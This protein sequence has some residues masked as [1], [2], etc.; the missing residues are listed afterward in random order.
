LEDAGGFYKI[1]NGG[2]A[3]QAG[4]NIMGIFVRKCKDS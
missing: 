3:I 4:K 2:V 1:F